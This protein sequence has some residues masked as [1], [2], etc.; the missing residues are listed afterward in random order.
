MFMFTI[1]SYKDPY[2]VPSPPSPIGRRPLL[3]NPNT[4][5][6]KVRGIRRRVGGPYS[7]PLSLGNLRVPASSLDHC[8]DPYYF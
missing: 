5:W 1:P 7:I 8:T 6:W 4:N 3:I 2:P